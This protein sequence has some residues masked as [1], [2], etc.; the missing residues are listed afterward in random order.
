M[1]LVTSVVFA[2]TF[3]CAIVASAQEQASNGISVGRPKVYDNRSLTIMLE[4]LGQT[5]QGVQFVNQTTVAAAIPNLQGT[6]TTE[7][8]ASVSV[9]RLPIPT[10]R[11]G[12]TGTSFTP[13]PPTL[14]D[15]PTLSGFTPNFGANASDLLNDQ[16][17]L[18]Y[19][20]F[21]LRMI[22]ER[23]LSDRLIEDEPRMQAVLGFNVTIDPPRTAADAVAVV[24]VTLSSTTTFGK[25]LSLVAMMPQEKTYNAATLSTKARQ[26]GGSAIANVVEVGVNA[27][28]RTQTFYLYRDNDTIAYERM[29]PQHP[30]QLVFGWM[31]RP[32]LGRRSVSPGFRQMLAV[33]ALPL[34]D[35]CEGNDC[36]AESLKAGVRTYWKKY[37][38]STLTSFENRDANRATRFKYAAT[39]GLTRPELFETRYVNTNSYENIIVKPTSKFDKE[40][41]PKVT[42][43]TWTPVGTKNV[44]ISAVGKN[45]FTG[46]QLI[47]GDKTYGAAAGLILKSNNA[48]ELMVP[49]DALSA[50]P[51]VISGRYGKAK[52]FLIDDAE[53]G[54]SM[55]AD[56]GAAR[57]GVRDVTIRLLTKSRQ[58]IHLADL[59]RDAN[60]PRLFATPL[61]TIGGSTMPLPYD[62]AEKDGTVIIKGSITDGPSVTNSRLIRLS[63]PFRPAHWTAVIE[64]VDNAM[65][66]AISKN[67]AKNFLLQSREDRGFTE[68][69]RKQG[70]PKGTCWT[71]IYEGKPLPLDTDICHGD[72]RT[73]KVNSNAVLINFEAKEAVPEKVL[74][75]DP[76]GIPFSID[77]PKSPEPLAAAKPL[78]VNQFDSVFIE[79]PVK[80]FADVT[81]VEANQQALRFSE[82]PDDEK[83]IRVQVTRDLTAQPGN[84]DITVTED[85]KAKTTRLVIKPCKNCKEGKQ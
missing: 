66:F 31:F 69:I 55:S 59:P 70:L 39:F 5:L 51:G 29:D 56:I 34:K 17:N 67:G 38:P 41:E 27:R 7:D 46:T 40:L 11:T 68:D 73:V 23:S 13:T 63:W 74:L 76:G 36:P 58:P 80:K 79:L 8:L 20:I 19:Q 49:L 24:E 77:F 14:A 37:D 85:K 35:L 25:P 83:T 22:L 28:R 9:Q 10:P 6:Q 52:D 42:S 84:V 1:R 53:E 4:A 21:N 78:E 44:L 16:I 61:V 18:T 47:F 45:F 50:G 48:F 72:K 15:A 12:T 62:I 82:K 30:N 81:A 2:M 75:V 32:V 43:V 54:I 3:G 64:Q 71:L 57:A 26:F 65:N 33:A 60:D